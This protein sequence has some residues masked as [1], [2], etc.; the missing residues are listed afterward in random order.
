ME[1]LSLATLKRVFCI[2]IGGGD[3]FYVAKFLSLLK[4]KVD[5][6]D[7]SKSERT[8]ELE[9]LGINIDY[10]NPQKLNIPYNLVVF[11]DALPD[12]ILA[13]IKEKNPELSFIE[14]G[15]FKNILVG[16]YENDKLTSLE[17][18][19]FTDSNIAPLYN[20]DLGDMKLIGVTGT[21]G[22]TTVIS[23][24]YHI[25]TQLGHNAG[26]ITTVGAKMGNEEIDTGFHVTT[27]SA[28]D[29]YKTL[30]LMKSK[31]CTFAIIECT[32][33]GIYMGRL[34][35]LKFDV[36]VFT[37]IKSEHLGYHKTWEN[38]AHAKSLLISE[39]LKP[40]GVT[41]LNADDG[42]G[43]EYVN[44]VAKNKI[45]Y[46]LN[47]TLSNVDLKATD[48]EETKSGISFKVGHAVY[49][50]PVL[51]EFNVS[52]AL[53]SACSLKYFEIPT[54]TSLKKLSNF[55]PVVGRMNILQQTP[56]TVIVD[57]AHTPNGLL[58]VLKTAVKLKNADGKL[59]LV[60]GCAAKRDEYK[61]P[62]MGEYAKKFAD[63][64]ILTAEDCRSEG[65]KIINDQIA[66]G[67]EKLAMN[68]PRQLYRFD[69]E[70][71]NVQVRR[72]AIKKALDTAK[73]GD[74][75]LITGKGHEK[76]LCFGN[77]EYPWNDIEEATKLLQEKGKD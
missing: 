4:V 25:L 24:I 54:A 60:F 41:V 69:D 71:Q 57:F 17:K 66:E 70:S 20:I 64:T 51:G 37:N 36:A 31:G 14:V 68:E 47:N 29:I 44:K 5:G 53:A 61:R 56:F 18:K 62:V 39:H 63:I 38:Y 6:S 22:K 77:I 35:G 9:L 33:Q 65:L 30:S 19:S 46:S 2:G 15:I 76:S 21:D 73:Q 27:P 1:N 58:S 55:A 45:L 49:S 59:I 50:L 32:S 12:N 34:A 23:M 67:W 40:R 10:K 72:L 8:A 26:M 13:N 74:A 52:N 3:V 16:M 43:F 7:I 28:H 42:A 48:I 75:I 11:S